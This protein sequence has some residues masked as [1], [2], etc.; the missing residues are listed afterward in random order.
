MN[1]PRKLQS[2]D[3]LA[4]PGPDALGPDILDLGPFGGSW[5]SCIGSAIS[6]AQERADLVTHLAT[7][8]IPDTVPKTAQGRWLMDDPLVA[9]RFESLPSIKELRGH[10]RVVLA[11]GA[12][13]PDAA[14]QRVSSMLS[15]L[16]PWNLGNSL[17]LIGETWGRLP[18]TVQFPEGQ[19][20]SIDDLHRVCPAFGWQPEDLLA[21]LLSTKQRG[22][23][24][25]DV[26]GFLPGSD[27]FI[28]R[29]LA[30]VKAALMPPHNDQIEIWDRLR[31]LGAETIEL[32]LPEVCQAAT[33]TSKGLREIGKEL[34]ERVERGLAIDGLKNVTSTAK[35]TQRA[36]AVDL[37]GSIVVLGERPPLAA[38]ARAELG[39]DRS[40]VVRDAVDRIGKSQPIDEYVRPEL[41]IVDFPLLD[42][43]PAAHSDRWYPGAEDV[44]L[45]VINDAELLGDSVT[46]RRLVWQ[47]FSQESPLISDLHPSHL[48]RLLL[49]DP[50][51]LSHSA[52]RLVALLGGITLP[53]LLHL[54]AV[55]EHDEIGQRACIQVVTHLIDADQTMWTEAEVA[56][57][58]AYNT[59]ELLVLLGD[60]PEPY[61]WSRDGFFKVIEMAETLPK[62]LVVALVAAAVAGFKSDRADLYRIIDD[63]YVDQVLPSLTSKK[64]TERSG[65]AEWL[66]AHRVAAAAEPIRSAI[67][68][69]RDDNT[70]AT[71][72]SAL[73]ALCES[74]DEF[75]GREATAIDAGRAMAKNNAI[76]KAISWLDID[77]LPPLA[78]ADGKPVGKDV[79][80]WFIAT[81]VKAKT[82]EPSP[83]LRRHFANMDPALVQVFGATVLDLWLKADLRT[84]TDDE[85]LAKA[86]GQAAASFL[87]AQGGKGPFVGM[88]QEEIVETLRAMHRNTLFGSAADS[89]GL[90]AVA[91]VSAG[92]DVAGQ[93]LG[94]IRKYRGNRVNQAKALLQMLAWIDQPATVQAVMSVSNRFRPKGIQQEATRQAQLLAKRQGWTFDDLADRS[95][96]DGGFQ[97]D[98]RQTFHYGTRSFTAHL[99]NDLAVSL[100]NDETGKTIRSLPKGRADEDQ[101]VIGQVRKDLTAAK[102]DIKSAAALQPDRLRIAMCVQ[103]S[104]PVDNFTRYI[105]KHPVMARLGSALV[106]LA[107]SGDDRALA[108]FRP[109]VDGTLLDLDDEEVV[110]EDDAVVLIAHEQLLDPG[111]GDAWSRHMSDY[112]V[113]PL[114]AQFGR[115]SFEVSEG[116]TEIEEFNGRTMIDGALRGQMNRLGW[117]LGV[118]GDAG[119]VTEVVKDLPGSEL[120][121]VLQ[122]TDGIPAGP[123]DVQTWETGLGTLF[124]V[125]YR[126][127]DEPSAARR[128]AD[129]PRI[130]LTEIYAEAR[131]I[132]AAGSDAGAAT[133][134]P[135]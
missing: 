67:R 28:R 65:A 114:F 72:L 38:W 134:T 5:Q 40:A 32:L 110:L 74:L 9:Y 101:D 52:N 78:W 61:Y 25:F 45:S 17:R 7:G 22:S 116:Q 47:A 18:I 68:T 105:I 104:W 129:V 88:T 81:A 92:G 59:D 79:V 23:H 117:Q 12:A 58:V 93:V 107:R 62:H 97:T 102:K 86:Q 48:S 85:A 121:A 89:K 106:W 131:E 135:A 69:E 56:E 31:P 35:P 91:A 10:P 66:S 27:D 118:P 43:L 133:A 6:S 34:L 73:E 71:L 16:T 80:A 100:T 49:A 125:G 57:W 127:P 2:Q 11:A 63:R 128:L 123:A 90:L 103:R 37:L 54:S 96:P 83:I 26:V 41:P 53:P 109:L 24:V 87:W 36:N 60:R 20:T 111:S 98:G 44:L 51:S 94:Y 108:V 50:R 112:Q 115:L 3:E 82:A 19:S 39:D 122:L 15:N 120:K 8:D 99:G 130:L 84:Y 75:M 30:S 1:R 42:Q 33:T 70:K 14:R 21:G 132:T 4:G 77:A 13:M 64:R 124:F 119:I 46:R 126:D 55:A 113:T 95:V 29:E 76:P